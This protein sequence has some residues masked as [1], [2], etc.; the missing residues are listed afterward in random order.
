MLKKIFCLLISYIV[1]NHLAKHGTSV[2]H[3]NCLA[4]DEKMIE[5]NCVTVPIETI[6]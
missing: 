4:V 6:I 2:L 5:Q 3:Y 1:H